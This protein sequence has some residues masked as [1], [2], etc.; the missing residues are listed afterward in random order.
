MA[1]K[2]YA[3]ENG[4]QI[5]RVQIRIEDAP[6]LKFPSA[7]DCNS[8][9]W[10]AEGKFYILNSTGHP[11]RSS[12]ENV[13]NM[14]RGR[15]ITY[16]AWRDGGRW[17]ESVHQDADGTLFGW[18]HNEP[19]HLNQ[20]PETLQQG[21]QFRLT[22][23]FIGAVV[24]Y[25]NGDTWDDL[26]LVITGGP[27]TLNVEAPNFWFAGGNGDFSVILDQ[28]NAY[29]YFLFGAY[30]KDVTQQG[31][32]LARMRCAD[33]YG[34]VGRVMKWC[35]GSWG[36]PGLRGAVTPVLPVRS[37]WYSPEPDTFWG[38]SVHWNHHIQ[39]YVILMN[40]AIDPRW[41]QE[42]IYLCMTPDISDPTS[43]TEPLRILETKGWYPQVIGMD[44]ARRETERAA[45]E[46]A[47]LFIHG[48]SNHI[49]R[50][51]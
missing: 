1:A 48:E 16:T 39:Q 43:W 32:C 7:T 15:E 19:A 21:R 30:Y 25:D 38:P 44:T 35:N 4:W 23:P 31:I 8:P 42:G 11:T 50:F 12:G 20:I 36:E 45:G 51:A 10:W 9:S 27:D 26:G 41:K 18:Y 13:E 5:G 46:S 14:T 6:T 37:D 22:A 33:R 49:M 40:H 2:A 24:S 17:I 3:E 28:E 34:P 47:R 29:F